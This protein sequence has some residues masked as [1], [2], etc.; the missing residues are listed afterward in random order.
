MPGSPRTPFTKDFETT[1]RKLRLLLF[2]SALTLIAAGAF[3]QSASIA[4]SLD[5]TSVLPGLPTSAR[6]I[7]RNE[8]STPMAFAG[9]INLLVN[10]SDGSAVELIDEQGQPLTLLVPD[11][12]TAALNVPP[13]AT[14]TLY[15][16]MNY[17]L[18]EPPFFVRSWS[19]PDTYTLAVRMRTIDDR[20]IASPPIT[21]TVR[22][23]TGVDAQVWALLDSTT[24]GNGWGILDW[25]RQTGIAEQV[26]KQWP[27]S[28]YAP[29]LV[30][31]LSAGRSTAIVAANIDG[32]IEQTPVGPWRETLL[33]ASANAHNGAALQI[34][35]EQRNLQLA[36][37]ESNRARS[38]AERLLREGTSQYLKA[39]ANDELK[40]VQTLAD[41]E[42]LAAAYRRQNPNPTRKVVPIVE[43]IT[44]VAKGFIAQFGYDNPNASA[45]EVQI[46]GDNKFS[47]QPQDR[48]Q[49]RLFLV[50]KNT[51][52]FRVTSDGSALVW[53]L[54]GTSVNVNKNFDK[55]CAN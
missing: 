37:E 2:T 50:G 24:A 11:D 13:H 28:N 12:Q 5:E 46:G 18:L 8:T 26:I 31:H 33:L 47:G 35:G 44:P 9:L 19:K 16:P 3:A 20:E 34:Y 23:P 42:A 38:S 45:R 14:S 49:P 21:F 1:M 40:K 51:N 43:C 41:W 4:L 7:L 53:K 32:A 6:V 48:Q 36:T 22:K 55:R 10:R 30:S 17:M 27:T 25:F 52:V 54:D 15:F 39:R 29:Y